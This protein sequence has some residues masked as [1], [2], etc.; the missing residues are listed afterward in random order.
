MRTSPSD[1]PVFRF[2]NPD[3]TVHL[4]DGHR[5]TSVGEAETWLSRAD[6]GLV[7]GLI[8]YDRGGSC[9]LFGGEP[10]S[11]GPEPVASQP[12]FRYEVPFNAAEAER[13]LGSL[14]AALTALGEDGAELEK[15]VLA[16][17][18]RYAVADELDVDGLYG[19]IREAY[20][21]GNNFCVR[22]LQQQHAYHL[23]SSP[24]L[25]LRR[26]GNRIVL[27]PLAGTLP[28]D[29]SLSDEQDRDRAHRLLDTPKFR[30][31]HAYLV[32]FMRE[33]LQPWCS[34]LVVPSEPGLV[35]A[36]N[37][38]HLGTFIE[39]ALRRDQ[40]TF[41]ELVESLHPSPAV[42]GVPRDAANAFI[43]EHEGQRGYYAG[44]VGWFDGPRDCEFYMALRSMGA[45]VARGHVEL[46]AGG[47][48]VRGS[49]IPMEF[50]E[51][52]AKMSTMQRV[53]GVDGRSRVPA[54]R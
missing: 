41:S 6:G 54:G 34:Q 5:F 28:K 30:S 26:R 39:G 20:P 49:S 23:G 19:T 11:A 7:G 51:V 42:C 35:S 31:E 3:R 43:A 22:D 25:F 10:R 9:S 15:V 4:A 47:G 1:T 52:G 44:L 12:H 53:L 29:P 8:P 13:Y 27:H 2:A 45:D 33:R 32:D 17:A 16:R 37:V 46:R 50:G 38:W 48:I 40:T 21:N 36:P 18:E 24:E 14:D